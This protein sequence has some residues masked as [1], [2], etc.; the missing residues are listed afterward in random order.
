MEKYVT[1]GHATDD[2]I[3]QRARFVCWLNKA[4]GTHSEHVI[5]RFKTK[6]LRERVSSLRYMYTACLVFLLSFLTFA[7]KCNSNSTSLFSFFNFDFVS[8]FYLIF[9][10]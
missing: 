1:A 10:F 4:I 9:S 2:N 6:W 3:I 7:F 8:S 5:M